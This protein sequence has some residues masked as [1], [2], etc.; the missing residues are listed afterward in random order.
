MIL[1]SGTQNL[2][3]NIEVYVNK[4]LT[5]KYLKNTRLPKCEENVLTLGASTTAARLTITVTHARQTVW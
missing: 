3:N 5:Y 4:H 2:N 1:L